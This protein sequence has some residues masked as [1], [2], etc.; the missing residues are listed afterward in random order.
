MR[1]MSTTP[2]G[3]AYIRSFVGAAPAGR[4]VLL[5]MEADSIE[6]W[7]NTASWYNASFVWAAMNDFGGTNGMFG[8]VANV[9]QRT[10]Q[11]A[12]SAPS[13]AGVGV[14]ME[15]WV[16]PPVSAPHPPHTHT[17]AHAHTHTNTH[18]HT[19]TRTR[20][21]THTYHPAHVNR[22]EHRK[23]STSYILW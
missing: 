23:P 5:D 4:L 8:D 12:E 6:I 21:H 1:A 13:F 9:F 3:K 22:P 15:G 7:R 20:T 14:T 10:A 11:T 19:R 2:Q 17:H 16:L 18:T